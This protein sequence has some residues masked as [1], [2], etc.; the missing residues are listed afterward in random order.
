MLDTMATE[1]LEL[2]NSVGSSASTVSSILMPNDE[3]N[4]C[5][6]LLLPFEVIRRVFSQLDYRDLI[7]CSLACK[8]W[9]AD[10]EN[11]REGWKEEYWEA[12]SVRGLIQW[13]SNPPRARYDAYLAC[14]PD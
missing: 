14:S 6:A 7:N 10:S 11:L 3:G 13:D 1:E 9:H 8:Q 2:R 12:C 4:R 5:V